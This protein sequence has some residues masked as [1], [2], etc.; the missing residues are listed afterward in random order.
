MRN[1]KAIAMDKTNANLAL[2]MGAI[3]FAI[4]GVAFFNPFDIDRTEA[5]NILDRCCGHPA[6]NNQY[7]YHKYPVCV[8][9]PFVD[10]GGGTF[11]PNRLRPRWLP[12][13]RPVR[14]EGT[15]GQGR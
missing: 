6:P 1:P 14:C 10:D 12:V 11:S 3:G 5:V 15:N 7:H 9:S 4:N 8:K 2:P 13:V